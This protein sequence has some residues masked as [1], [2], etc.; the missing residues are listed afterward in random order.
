MLAMK[1][2]ALAFWSLLFVGLVTVI[3]GPWFPLVAFIAVVVYGVTDAARKVTRT[4]RQPE[5]A[6]QETLAIA[7]TNARRGAEQAVAK[8]EEGYGSI[9][10]PEGIALMAGPRDAFVVPMGR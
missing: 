6:R 9:L 3:A 1:L 5:Q 10:T 2:L 7:E 8:A 4:A